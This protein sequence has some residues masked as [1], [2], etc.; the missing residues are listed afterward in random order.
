MGST[1]SSP[2]NL[3]IVDSEGRHSRVSIA[4]MDLSDTPA[5]LAN[6][7]IE[8][9]LRILNSLN[10]TTFAPSWM[11]RYTSARVNQPFDVDTRG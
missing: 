5:A 4:L 2:V 3:R 7:L 11:M 8:Y 6:P 10:R 1:F 9:S